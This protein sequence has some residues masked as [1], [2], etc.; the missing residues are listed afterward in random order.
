MTGE[1]SGTNHQ[2]AQLV[3][4]SGYTYEALARAV[5]RVAAENGQPV[6]T[7]RSNV[8]HWIRYGVRPNPRVATFLAEALTRRIGTV[9]TPEDFGCASAADAP[10]WD[11]DTLTSLAELR[12]MDVLTDR[13][14]ALVYSAAALSVP[15]AAWWS[16]AAR[17]ASTYEGK[18]R[19]VGIGDVQAVREVTA[20]FSRVDQRHGGGHARSAVVSYLTGEVTSLIHGSYRDEHTRRAAFTAG[21]ELC[22]LAGWMAFDAGEHA[23]A[24]RFLMA[25]VKLAA[26]ANDLPLAGHVLRALAHQALDLGHPR[27]AVELS[28]AAMAGERYRGACSR[29][30]A[31]FGVVHG[32]ALAEVGEKTRAARVLL[33][34]EKDLAA[35]D[36][37]DEPDRVFFFGEASLAHETALA[38]RTMGDL[39]AAATQLGCSVQARNI[40]NFARTH[41]VTL[42]YLGQV[43]AEQGDIEHACATWLSA[44]EAMDGVRSGRTRAAA[45]AMRRT[46]SPLRRRGPSYV[47]QVDEAAATYLAAF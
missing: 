34:A 47:N 27:S 15:G 39:K 25:A 33:D 38:L 23:P 46:L 2:L 21:G 20:L 40:G 22:Y 41:A 1:S 43:Q 35:S 32:R 30:R 3:A 10:D 12:R 19:A 44:L 18:G 9:L 13:R 6:A 42:G 26:E 28:G 16:R 17:L 29:E 37:A 36:G 45:D 24:Q 31:L 14:G 8:T 4:R 7:N 5:R 11:T